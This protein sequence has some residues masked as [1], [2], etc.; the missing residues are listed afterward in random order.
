[1]YSLDVQHVVYSLPLCSWQWYTCTVYGL[2]K[3][4]WL[5]EEEPFSLVVGDVRQLWEVR[6]LLQEGVSP[7]ATF[8]LDRIKERIASGEYHLPGLAS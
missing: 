7:T 4:T 5:R 1:M 2:Y 3:L 8:C 6:G